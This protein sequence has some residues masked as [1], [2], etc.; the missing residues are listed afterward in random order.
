MK[1]RVNV[2]APGKG[3]VARHLFNGQIQTE[4][5]LTGGPGRVILISIKGL[6]C[7]LCFSLCA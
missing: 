3:Q 6:L 7:Y 4:T 2:S 1:L 5:T